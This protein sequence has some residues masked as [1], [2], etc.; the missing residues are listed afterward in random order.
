MPS[1]PDFMP[2]IL[3]LQGRQTMEHA[4]NLRQK[5]CFSQKGVLNTLRS[6]MRHRPVSSRC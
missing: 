3:H 6:V 1:T 2:G 5:A 4:P